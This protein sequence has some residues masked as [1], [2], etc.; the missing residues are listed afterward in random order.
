MSCVSRSNKHNTKIGFLFKVIWGELLTRD[1]AKLTELRNVLL[2]ETTLKESLSKFLGKI[3]EDLATNTINRLNAVASLIAKLEKSTVKLNKIEAEIS[4]LFTRFLEYVLSSSTPG[5]VNIGLFGFISDKLKKMLGGRVRIEYKVSGYH[6]LEP[7]C[8]L[9]FLD[10]AVGLGYE[11]VTGQGNRVPM[12]NLY[13]STPAYE[14]RSL[15]EALRSC[16]PVI[17][18]RKGA[19]TLAV[20]FKP[21]LWY[22][23]GISPLIQVFRGMVHIDRHI[24]SRKRG[25]QTKIV[26]HLKIVNGKKVTHYAEVHEYMAW[27]RNNIEIAKLQPIYTLYMGEFTNRIGIGK[28]RLMSIGYEKGITPKQLRRIREIIVEDLQDLEIV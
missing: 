9:L 15:D 22:K 5:I 16:S 11:V 23:L 4:S 3:G 28:E 2:S 20:F 12:L 1:K 18:L 26:A 7:I 19:S 21:I 27:Y 8:F 14:Y 13:V 10:A 24:G 25:A 6:I 17:H